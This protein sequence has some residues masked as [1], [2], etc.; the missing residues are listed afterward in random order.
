MTNQFLA[1]LAH[2]P[3]RSF[4]AG[5][6]ILRQGEKRGQVYVLL[7]GSVEVVKND[8]RICVVSEPG[9]I[10]GE[11]SILLNIYHTAT[12]RTLEPSSFHLIENAAQFLSENPVATLHVARL[13][14]RRLALLDSYF[15]E[16]KTDFVK[17]KEQLKEATPAQPADTTALTSFWSKAEKGIVQRWYLTPRGD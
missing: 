11:L 8:A 7:R 1:S 12:V 5:C 15:S 9:A 14:A 6:E 4:E 3:E 13:L 17:V 2:L 10:L 16:L